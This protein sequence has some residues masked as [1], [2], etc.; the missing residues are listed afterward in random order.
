ME[1]KNCL[2][3]QRRAQIGHRTFSSVSGCFFNHKSEKKIHTQT[4]TTK[5]VEY[6]CPSLLFIHRVVFC[7]W[8]SS[9]SGG[10]FL[11]FLPQRLRLLFQPLII[12]PLVILVQ[13]KNSLSKF[14]DKTKRNANFCNF[15]FFLQTTVASASWLLV[16]DQR[17]LKVSRIPGFCHNQFCH[18]K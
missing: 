14:L 10:W 15:F 17:L 12:D 4:N 1:G 8:T 11:L 16:F 9:A 13:L 7:S 2:L 3:I 18:E 5:R 6:K